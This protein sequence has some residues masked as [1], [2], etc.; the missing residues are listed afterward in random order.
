VPSGPLHQDGQASVSFIAIVPPLLLA[1]GVLIQAA[2]VG[3]TAWSAA[4]AAR[5]AAR[6]ELVGSEVE[7][8]AR[9]ALPR[10]LA[11][12][13][14]V[15]VGGRLVRVEV[16]APKLVPLG[17]AFEVGSGAVLDPRGEG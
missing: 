4:N 13:A 12:R 17:P 2:V 7:A 11:D 14:E 16:R 3:W 6:A 10:A 9:A 5:A 8:A 1:C 15:D